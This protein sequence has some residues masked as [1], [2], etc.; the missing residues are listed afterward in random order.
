[1]TSQMLSTSNNWLNHPP[2]TSPSG[3]CAHGTPGPLLPHTQLTPALRS[4][5]T[6]VSSTSA[7]GSHCLVASQAPSPSPAGRFCSKASLPTVLASK[8]PH[9]LLTKPGRGLDRDQGLKA[10]PTAW[11]LEGKEEPGRECTPGTRG[12][13]EPLF[14]F[15]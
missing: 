8:R 5:Y 4:A 9:L 13:R 14:P 11:M 7:S 12:W 10:N 2:Q 15:S 3:N 1:V 6:R